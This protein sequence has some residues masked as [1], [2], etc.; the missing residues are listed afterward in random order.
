MGK[1]I[2][3]SGIATGKALPL[4]GA[5][6]SFLQDN[7]EENISNIIKSLIGTYTTNDVII[8]YG[9]VFT[10]TDPGARTMTSGAIY[11]NG[12]V[13]NV[14]SASFTTT[15]SNIPLWTIVQTQDASDPALMS[16]GTTQDVCDISQFVLT[17]GL[18]GGSGV[19]GYISDYNSSTVKNLREDW[20]LATS[21]FATGWTNSGGADPVLKY[22]KGIAG[23]VTITG[24][25][26]KPSGTGTSLAFTLP[27]G[28]RPSETFYSC[29]FRMKTSGSDVAANC[30]IDSAGLVTIVSIDRTTL[31][32]NNFF[33]SVKFSP[34]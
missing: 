14:P 18:P 2:N 22:R 23:D 30:S 9:C 21:E 34:K 11:Y 24:V 15:G 16:D 5:R 13:Y 32:T 28:Y 12:I 10:G 1:R 4:N 25:I 27:A 29:Y 7:V 33:I 19:I 17:Q 26:K 6:L 3:T 20:I 8:L 31:N